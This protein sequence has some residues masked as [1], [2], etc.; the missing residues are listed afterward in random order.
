[1]GFDSIPLV[2]LSFDSLRLSRAGR[3]LLDDVSGRFRHGEL[4]VVLGPSGAGKTTLLQVLAGKLVADS[5]AVRL[6]GQPAA[7]SLLC[8]SGRLGCSQLLACRT[9]IQT[10]RPGFG[11]APSR[12]PRATR[13]LKIASAS[14]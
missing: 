14:P 10:R 13:T 11:G 8:L 9:G 5:G 4:S 6:N 1:M 2:D 3:R 7:P 12:R